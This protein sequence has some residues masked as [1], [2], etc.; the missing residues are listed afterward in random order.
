MAVARRIPSA[1][2]LGQVLL[3]RLGHPTALAGRLDARVAFDA[4]PNE[5]WS[6][7]INGRTVSLSPGLDPE[8]D[9]TIRSDAETLLGVI[10][11]RVSGVE[12]FLDGR[13]T[14]RG[15]LSLS[16]QME[17]MFAMDAPRPA[18]FPRP[19]HVVAADIDTFYLEA[20]EGPPVVL[21]HGLGATNASMLPPLWD[22]ARDHRVLAPDLPGFGDSSKPFRSYNAEFYASW[23]AAFL[24]ETGIERADIVGN[25]MGGRIAIELGLV[26]P[27]RV[28]RLVLLAPSPAFI[29]HRQ[30]TG[31]VKYLRPELAFVPLPLPHKRVVAS[32]KQLFSK[33]E[34]LPDAWYDAA[35]DEFRRVFDSPSGRVSFFSAARQIYLEEPFGETGFWDRLPSLQPPSLFVWGQ[36]DRL[37]PAK[38]APRVERALPAATSVVLPDCGHVPQFELPEK[39]NALIREFIGVGAAA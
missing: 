27:E 22:L 20:G 4:G 21:V 39:T 6:I 19:D 7:H 1:A 5:Q 12:A 16:L 2:T 17:G 8:A 13:L 3:P 25:S 10:E 24:D 33:P 34:R 15:N 18:R 26:A 36:Q 28:N 32:T 14:V 30:F 29:K 31:L 11:G 23:L 38:F 35:A 9:T 37:V